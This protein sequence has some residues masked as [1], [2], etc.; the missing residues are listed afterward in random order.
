MLELTLAFQRSDQFDVIHSHVDFLAFPV[1]QFSSTPTVH[2]LH[3]RLDLPYLRP[4]YRQFRETPL[5]SISDA[6]RDP[7]RD[8]GLSWLGTVYHGLPPDEYPFGHGAGRYLAFL[9]RMSPEKRPDLAIQVATR[10]GIPI[11]LAAKVDQSNRA[12]FDRVIGPLLDGPLVDFIGE[13]GGA[14]RLKFLSDALALI[15]P[16]DWPEPFGLVM[17][18]ALACGT[19][20]VAFRRGSVPEVLVDGETGFIVDDFDGMVRAVERVSSLDRAACRRD[21]ERRFTDERMAA[22]YERLYL[23]AIERGPRHR[24]LQAPS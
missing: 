21:I 7:L 2:T 3:G 10:V 24:P 4:I 9:G 17:I 8:L 23:D 1:A 18:E 11:K 15:F 22:G 12:Y 14:E 6:Q 5:V 16:I 20:V 19:P 13:V